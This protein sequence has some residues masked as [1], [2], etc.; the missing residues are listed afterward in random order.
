[1]IAKKIGVSRTVVREAMSKLEFMNMLTP[2]PHRGNLILPVAQWKTRND[3]VI[4]WAERA[5]KAAA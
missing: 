4:A 1:V 3:D 5:Q 2:Y